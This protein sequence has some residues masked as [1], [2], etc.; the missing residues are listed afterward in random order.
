MA[1]ELARKAWFRHIAESGGLRQVD[2]VAAS[3][4]TEA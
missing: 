4:P 3:M 1:I 2:V